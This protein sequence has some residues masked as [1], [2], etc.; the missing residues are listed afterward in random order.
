MKNNAALWYPCNSVLHP[1][2]VLHSQCQKPKAVKNLTKT[3]NYWINESYW[4]FAKLQKNG[5]LAKAR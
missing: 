4:S 1:L 2:T 3:G 5:H